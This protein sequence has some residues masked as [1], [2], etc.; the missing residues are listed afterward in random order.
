MNGTTS[1]LYGDSQL[2]YL[3]ENLVRMFRGGRHVEIGERR[4]LATSHRQV[5]VVKIKKPQNPYDEHEPIVEVECTLPSGD[6][7]RSLIRFDELR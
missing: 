4:I 5:E 1:E 3:G 2:I 7:I 6:K